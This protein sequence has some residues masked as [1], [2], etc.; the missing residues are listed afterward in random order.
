MEA[1]HGL[2]G[3]T[4]S[5]IE[6]PDCTKGAFHALRSN[7]WLEREENSGHKVC[8]VLLALPLRRGKWPLPSCVETE[9]TFA[10]EEGLLGR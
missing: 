1:T 3:M 8:K 9:M 7:G 6:T 4:A 5:R 10:G 2:G